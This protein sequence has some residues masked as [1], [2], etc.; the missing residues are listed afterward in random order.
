MKALIL[1]GG[2][3]SRLKEVTLD[4]NKCMCLYHGRHI[5]DNSL[6][7]AVRVG[8]EEIVIV[9]GYRAEMI[10]N[11]LGN[12]YQGVRIRYV[13]QWEQKGVV[14]AME[15]A[16]TALDGQDFFLTLADE[17]IIDPRHRAMRQLF[18]DQDVFVLCG[19]V[20]VLDVNQI[21]KTY[22]VM[23][24]AEAGQIYRLI[25]KPRTPLGNLQGTGNCMFRNE[26]FDYIPHTPINQQRQEKELPDLIQC[27]VDEGRL[28]K[29]F[30]VGS[31]YANVNTSDELNNE[32]IVP[33]IEP[34]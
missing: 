10:I 4:R 34:V 16:R 9:V 32:L 27:A 31:L 21:K 30:D 15:C 28:V 20:R 19:V 13:I 18:E 11:A 25:E 1:A 22:G 29:I 6:E 3:G 7:N 26:I 23:V 12:C 14:H 17:V 2:R 33:D 8:V 5:I 24:N